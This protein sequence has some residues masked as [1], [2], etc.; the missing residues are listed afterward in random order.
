MF[1]EAGRRP[2]LPIPRPLCPSPCLLIGVNG[3]LVLGASPAVLRHY[4]L[5]ADAGSCNSPAALGLLEARSTNGRLVLLLPVDLR[6]SIPADQ[7]G[8]DPSG[9]EGR[10]LSSVRCHIMR[11]ARLCVPCLGA[12]AL[13]ELSIRHFIENHLAASPGPS[14]LIIAPLRHNLLG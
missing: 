12:P 3:G 11:G 6:P 8:D 13:K 5:D 14:P 4:A 1:L 9:G 7:G 10:D 2:F